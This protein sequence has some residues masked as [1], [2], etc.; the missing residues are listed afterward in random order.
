VVIY[1]R[2]VEGN[3]GTGP[4]ERGKVNMVKAGRGFTTTKPRELHMV[5]KRTQKAKHN[6]KV[7]QYQRVLGK[8][9]G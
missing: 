7:G 1:R 9:S 3:R 8:I 5:G 4:K 2:H 6:Q